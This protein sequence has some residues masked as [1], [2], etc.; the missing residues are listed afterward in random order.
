MGTISFETAITDPTFTLNPVTIGF[1]PRDAWA[2]AELPFG[3]LVTSFFRRR[4]SMHCKFPYKL[5]N[6]LL[7]TDRL[8][9]FYPLVGVKWV[10]VDVFM[11]EKLIFARLL[12]VRTIDGSFFHQQGNFPSHGFIELSFQEAREIGA[13]AGIYEI[14]TST[15][16]FLRHAQGKFTRYNREMEPDTLK[17]TKA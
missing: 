16:R 2:D 1:V 6:A 14:D 9:S 7:L 12:G 11:V 15:M 8:P 10:T 4:N 3:Q 13:E 5:F 17:W